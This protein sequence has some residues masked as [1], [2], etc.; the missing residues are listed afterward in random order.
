VYLSAI[1][2]CHYKENK[3]TNL[4]MHFA[5]KKSNIIQHSW[6]ELKPSIILLSFY[7]PVLIV[8][9]G[10][11]TSKDNQQEAQ[12]TRVTILPKVAV[13]FLQGDG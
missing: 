13:K 10:K 12:N 1:R 3:A 6:K 4:P 8:V 11:F 7:F 5:G 2:A 9:R